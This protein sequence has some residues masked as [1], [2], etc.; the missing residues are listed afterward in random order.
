V[1]TALNGVTVYNAMDGKGNDARAHEVLDGCEGHPNQSNYHYHSGSKCA[2]KSFNSKAST[3]TLWGYADDGF[4][5]YLV[6]NGSGNFLTNSQLDK[7]HGRTAKVKFNAKKQRIYHYVINDEYPYI[8]GCFKGTATS[9]GSSA[10]QAITSPQGSQDPPNRPE[11]A[12]RPPV[13]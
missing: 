10:G 8:L 3:S 7:C 9:R 4:G 11:P 6:R 5:I 13:S 2:I 1:A 12:E